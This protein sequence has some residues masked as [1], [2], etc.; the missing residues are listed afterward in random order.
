MPKRQSAAGIGLREKRQL[1]KK[2]SRVKEAAIPAETLAE[3]FPPI[4]LP[5]QPPY[6]PAEAK[7]VPEIPKE[8][9]WLYDAQV[10]W[11]S[12]SCFS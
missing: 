1:R 2:T 6:P 5:L 3:G 7:S 10:G 11:V 4:D 9:G 12:L 8:P